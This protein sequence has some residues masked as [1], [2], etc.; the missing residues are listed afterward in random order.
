MTGATKKVAE[1]KSAVE[2]S[3]VSVEIEPFEPT[4]T[5]DDFAKLDLRVAKVLQCE[6]VPE[7]NK[8]LK[9]TLDAGSETRQVFLGIKSA[10]SNPEALEGRL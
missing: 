3:D 6:A 1:E 7:S 8:L 5:I 10:Y 4:I 9:F 2:K